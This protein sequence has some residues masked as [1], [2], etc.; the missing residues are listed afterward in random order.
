MI[1]KNSLIVVTGGAGFIGSNLVR[2]LNKAGYENIRVVD[3]LT[4]G[5]KFKNLSG[6][7]FG[8]QDKD[9]FY[10]DILHSR[11]DFDYVFHLGAISSTT[12]KNGKE[13]MEQNYQ[14]SVDLIFACFTDKI[15][16]QYASSASVYGNCID[17]SEEPLNAYAFSKQMIDVFVKDLLSDELP[18][19]Q[20]LGLRYHNVMG[21]G[22][23]HKDGQ[24]SPVYSF[25]KQIVETGEIKLFDVNSQRDFIHVEDVC[26]IHLW[27]M[28][29]QMSGVVDVGT[30]TST[31]FKDVAEIICEEMA[32][33]NPDMNIPRITTVSFP[34]HLMGRYQYFTQAKHF[35]NAGY[36]EK[37]L[38]TEQG[39]RK[40]VRYLE[41][42][43]H[44]NLDL[45]NKYKIE[46]AYKYEL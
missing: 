43:R 31:S 2:T 10:E 41:K 29:N 4:D 13:L 36:T 15:P 37:L 34:D 28:E 35:L 17:D 12:H 11:I 19:T 8:Y 45:H 20:I 30:G 26:K 40:Y 1:D 21:P 38:T 39:V 7:L 22:E 16:I 5:R 3:D 18:E 23:F 9:E 25:W 24:S 42:N 46:R 6:C 14:C 32:K 33:L 27:L 44:K